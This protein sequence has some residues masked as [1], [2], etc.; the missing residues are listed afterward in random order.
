MGHNHNIYD[1]D[2]HFKIEPISRKIIKEPSAKTTLIQGDHNSERFTFEIA[3]MV[4]GHDMS[5]STR[6]E[7]H[8]IN[9]ASD[10][11]RQS[12]DVYIIDD[13]QISPESENV[14]IFSWLVSGSATRY[15]G[16]LTFAVRFICTTGEKIDYAWHTAPYKGISITEGIN[17]FENPDSDL[18]DILSDFERRLDAFEN[19]KDGADGKTPTLKLENGE[20]KVSYDNGNSWASLGNIQGTNGTNGTD[21][22]TPTLKL[23]NGEFTVSYD[24]GETWEF[25]GNGGSGSGWQDGYVSGANEYLVDV[26]FTSADAT[27]R[28]TAHN[29]HVPMLGR[30]GFQTEQILY[31]MKKSDSGIYAYYGLIYVQLF[32]VNDSNCTLT[33]NSDDTIILNNSAKITHIASRM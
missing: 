21:G 25:L 29:M 3:K 32:W 18:T 20:L 30:T 2:P 9:V 5:Q 6:I 26:T 15:A 27:W 12:E 17:A 8:F 24:N 33:K 14:L 31:V 16:T 4:E 13:M 10:N 1:S 28:A 11:K 22:K 19:G 23:E 7:V